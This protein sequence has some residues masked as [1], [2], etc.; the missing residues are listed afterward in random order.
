MSA[1]ERARILEGVSGAVFFL[2]GQNDTALTLREI[3]EHDR[4]TQS[5]GRALMICRE[6]DREVIDRRWPGRFR[7]L[8]QR[9]IG[10]AHEGLALLLDER[11]PEVSK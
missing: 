10:R 4:W 2:T 6:E 7:V 8:S 11:L 9:T 3:A 5:P 1:G